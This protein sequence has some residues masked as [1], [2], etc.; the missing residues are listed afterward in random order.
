V[1][2]HVVWNHSR[3]RERTNTDSA[4]PVRLAA[5][6]IPLTS[7][8]AC[9]LAILLQLFSCF[10]LVPANG[11]NT[12]YNVSMVTEQSADLR[13]HH[14]RSCFSWPDSSSH[15]LLHGDSNSNCLCF[16]S[17][18]NKTTKSSGWCYIVSIEV[19]FTAGTLSQTWQNHTVIYSSF[20]TRL[21]GRVAQ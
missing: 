15:I 19:Y 6:L 9:I 17:A 16:A 3:V 2:A 13:L 8:V 11:K 18:K 21:L 10:L 12:T 7:F 20:L 5:F 14:K 4:S 1:T